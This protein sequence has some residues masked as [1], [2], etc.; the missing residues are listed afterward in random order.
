MF[1]TGL[2]GRYSPGPQTSPRH[3]RKPLCP[4]IAVPRRADGW[5]IDINVLQAMRRLLHL[6]PTKFPT[7]C[8]GSGNSTLLFLSFVPSCPLAQDIHSSNPYN[9][10]ANI[11]IDIPQA[12]ALEQKQQQK[13]MSTVRPDPHPRGTM[14]PMQIQGEAGRQ[15]GTQAS[16]PTKDERRQ[17]CWTLGDRWSE[18]QRPR[19]PEFQD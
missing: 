6:S 14:I 1:P 10:C 5:R 3:L 4:S 8:P 13:P 11:I 19:N 16:S 2:L 12:D 17:S 7:R 15:A 18:R 9:I